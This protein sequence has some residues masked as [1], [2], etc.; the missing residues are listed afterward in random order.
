MFFNFFIGRQFGFDRALEVVQDEQYLDDVDFDEIRRYDIL[1]KI[2]EFNPNFNIPESH[3]KIQWQQ[4]RFIVSWNTRRLF[5]ANLWFPIFD[6]R[7]HIHFSTRT[8]KNA[9]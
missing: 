3:Q 9:N 2:G 5:P 7:H 1:K 8:L 6:N 4:G